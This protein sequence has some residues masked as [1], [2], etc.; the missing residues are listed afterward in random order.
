M[1]LKAVASY[2]V[3]NVDKIPEENELPVRLC[4]YTDVYNH[5]FITQP[6]HSLRGFGRKKVG[7]WRVPCH[8]ARVYENKNPEPEANAV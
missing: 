7:F 5:D 4:N 3:S 8:T 2:M 1:P 6:S